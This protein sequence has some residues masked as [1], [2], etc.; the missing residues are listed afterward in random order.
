VKLAKG[1]TNPDTF[2]MNG[3]EE[4]TNRR[5]EM[6][7]NLY[8]GNLAY[9]VTED[10]LKKNFGEIGKCI[11]ANIIKDRYSG[12]SRGFGFVEMATE[13]EAKEAIAKLSGTQILGRK[14]IVQEANPR[15][16]RKRTLYGR[17][18]FRRRGRF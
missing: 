10:D 18:D 2:F 16:E 7:S 17:S 9:E 5:I 1:D 11:S 12:K 15:S 13:D 8:V 4:F 6:S 14:I 3:H